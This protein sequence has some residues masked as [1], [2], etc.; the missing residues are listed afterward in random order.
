VEINRWY[1]RISNSDWLFRSSNDKRPLPLKYRTNL[2]YKWFLL[3]LSGCDCIYLRISIATTNII[4]KQKRIIFL[5]TRL[6]S[7]RVLGEFHRCTNRAHHCRILYDDD[8]KRHWTYAPVKADLALQLPIAVLS[9]VTV[10]NCCNP[11]EIL[12]LAWYIIHTYFIHA[13][14]YFIRLVSVYVLTKCVFNLFNFFWHYKSPPLPTVIRIR[15]IS[16]SC[17]IL[18]FCH[19]I[20]MDQMFNVNIR[21][22]NRKAPKFIRSRNQRRCV[23]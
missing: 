11:D 8:V 23:I 2:N 3:R 14:F 10:A 6:I 19:F 1:R 12:N 22:N 9:A 4:K 18:V 7:L 21:E 16:L 20:S 5:N 15:I 17:H 13:N